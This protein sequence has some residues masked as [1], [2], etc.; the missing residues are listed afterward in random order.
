M[1]PYTMPDIGKCWSF[2]IMNLDSAIMSL[3]SFVRKTRIDPLFN[4]DGLISLT[5]KQ[6]STSSGCGEDSILSGK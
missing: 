5:G 6:Y 4:Y 2:A 1:L 3:D